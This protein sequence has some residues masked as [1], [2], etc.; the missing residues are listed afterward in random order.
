MVRRGSAWA[1]KAGIF[2]NDRQK[3][4]ADRTKRGIERSLAVKEENRRREEAALREEQ[5]RQHRE[6]LAE[7]SF[8]RYVSYMKCFWCGLPYGKGLA[9]RTREHVIPRSQGGKDVSHN[10][11]YSHKMCNERR[12]SNMNWIPWH[13]HRQDGKVMWK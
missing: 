4:L 10:L 13:I 2:E 8:R 6:W 3:K 9:A 1:R 5:L 11:M 7:A 12:G